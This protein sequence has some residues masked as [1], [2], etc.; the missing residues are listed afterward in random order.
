MKKRVA[1]FITAYIPMISGAEVAVRE[2]TNGLEDCEF[3][4]YCAKLDKNLS[5]KEKIGN[6]FIHRIGVGYTI[7]KFLLPFFAFFKAL[8]EHRKNPYDLIWGVIASHG[9]LGALFFKMTTGTPF[10]L[11]LQEGDSPEHINRR[12]RFFRPLF[13][14]IFKEADYIQSISYYLKDWAKSQGAKCPIEIVPNGVDIEKFSQNFTI[15]ELESLRQ[16]LGIYKSDRVIITT[17]RLAPKNAIADAIKAV[18]EFNFFYRKFK[19]KF[20][21]I[22]KGALENELKELV[23]VLRLEGQ[24]LFLEYKLQEEIPK[25]LKISDIFIRPSLSEGF[26]NSFI[27]AMAA[28]IPSIA[29]PIGG[30]VDFMQDNAT[31]VFCE[32]NNP[33]SIAEK[34]NL[35]LS[36]D[37][38]RQEIIKNGKALV[39]EKYAWS[40]IVAQMREIFDKIFDKTNKKLIIGCE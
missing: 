35:L 7:D 16:D 24:V 32:V 18:K 12:T 27:E 39:E 28:G 26:G 40:I 36:D 37:N 23:K 9:S 19:L 38:L 22:G 15:E 29:T 13:R 11:T 20:L 21:I 3:D 30:I 4:L 31:G 33:K 25:Y 1:I 34:I 5:N 6:V 17:S 8:K 10:L 2:I 14:K